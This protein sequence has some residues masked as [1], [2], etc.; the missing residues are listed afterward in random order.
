MEFLNPL[1]PQLSCA[2]V[3]FEFNGTVSLEIGSNFLLTGS[4][5]D[6]NI[7]VISAKALFKT[8]IQK[9]NIDSLLSLTKQ[10]FNVD[11]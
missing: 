7:N 5:K 2:N 9:N 8:K 11:L 3:H 10:A 4:V 1:N 6:M